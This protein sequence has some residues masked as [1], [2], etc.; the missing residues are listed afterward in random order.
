MLYRSLYHDA[1]GKPAGTLML[2]IEITELFCHQLTKD[3]I[4]SFNLLS[5]S[6][7]A[8]LRCSW[9]RSMASLSA[10]P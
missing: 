3:P 2:A 6:Y 7:D 10:H 1:L 9:Y 8:P 5:I 4:P